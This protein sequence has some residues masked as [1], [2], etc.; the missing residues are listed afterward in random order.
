MTDSAQ[1]AAARGWI[2]AARRLVV[3]TGAGMST[4]S[5]ISDFR[6]PQGVWT[7]EP[8]SR[9]ESTIGFTTSPTP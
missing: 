5:G 2:D 7:Q 6:G 8:C 3:L 4:E 9:E 1:L